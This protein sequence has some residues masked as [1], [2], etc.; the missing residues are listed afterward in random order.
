MNPISLIT[1]FKYYI[2]ECRARKTSFYVS[3]PITI[4]WVFPGNREEKTFWTVVF[5]FCYQILRS[6]KSLNF[7]FNL[8]AIPKCCRNVHVLNGDV[9]VQKLEPVCKF[10][11]RIFHY[12]QKLNTSTMCFISLPYLTSYFIKI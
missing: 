6:V 3:F 8:N 5:P 9:K 7:Y 2:Y 1:I 11:V 4:V 10:E 12:K